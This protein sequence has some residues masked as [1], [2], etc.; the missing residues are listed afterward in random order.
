MAK[1]RAFKIFISSTF[2]DLV[3]E[4]NYIIDRVIKPFK[5]KAQLEYNVDVTVVDL[6]WGITPQEA[7]D[8]RVLEI[9]L[10]EIDNC[11]PLFIGI[12]GNR[13]GWC[14]PYEDFL[15][16]DFL[17]TRYP[18]MEEC[19]KQGLSITEMEMQY[20]AINSKIATDAIFFLQ[21]PDP[22]VQWTSGDKEGYEKLQRLRETISSNQS[23]T[24][25]KYKSGDLNSLS[26]GSLVHQLYEWLMRELTK[27]FPEKEESE[28]DLPICF[29]T[30]E[31]R[32][33]YLL[34]KLS[35]NAKTISDQ[36]AEIILGSEYAQTPWGM[37]SFI[38]DM[39][40]FGVFEEL[41]T[42]INWRA[43]VSIHEYD[44]F[45]WKRRFSMYSTYMIHT[46]QALA[47]SRNGVDTALAD[48][49]FYQDFIH[50]DEELYGSVFWDEMILS[51]LVDCVRNENGLLYTIADRY[52]DVACKLLLPDEDTIERTRIRLIEAILDG[53][54]YDKYFE[55]TSQEDSLY[56]EL[57]YQKAHCP[58]LERYACNW[59]DVCCS[60]MKNSFG[61]EYKTLNQIKEEGVNTLEDYRRVYAEARL[62]YEIYCTKNEGRLFDLLDYVRYHT[63]AEE[64]LPEN[65]IL[66]WKYLLD[67]KAPLSLL[68]AKSEFI[69]ESA[70]SWCDNIDYDID[71]L[72]PRIDDD[73]DLIGYEGDLDENL[74]PHGFGKAYYGNS[75]TYEGQWEHGKMHGYGIYE[76][77]GEYVYEGQFCD[78]RKEGK[79]AICYL[80]DCDG[81][82]M[83][84]RLEG[85][86]EYDQLNGYGTIRYASGHVYQGEFVDGKF[87][88]KGVYTSYWFRYEGDF[89]YGKFQG[90]G[91]LEFSEGKTFEGNFVDDCM[92]GEGVLC[93]PNGA[94]VAGCWEDD[95][96]VGL[97]TLT[98]PDGQQY[99]REY[100]DSEPEW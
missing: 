36:Q 75:D 18:E 86:F 72:F 23:I 30:I 26:Y 77:A 69:W 42:F 94:T 5:V 39:L 53:E 58:S 2:Q 80:S 85:E 73:M 71:S 99:Q 54:D 21:E 35:E 17:R 66:A 49:V 96:R 25:Y 81:Y 68:D 83:G 4:R 78:G 60:I 34:D 12:I 22:L 33:K 27:Y 28:D 50:K 48:K 46:L 45:V 16:N 100:T 1:K 74:L 32:K 55:Y 14:P 51:G 43:N 37:N 6:R 62:Y 40:T 13:Y 44:E 67:Y 64:I 56:Q 19:F 76:G 92:N 89:V 11:R 88:G 15:K 87:E 47:V 59:E 10:R 8:G 7:K 93:F 63:D 95:R 20:G 84:D 97:F 9:C 29:D 65:E 91:K 38:D 98:L 90:H 31:Q 24:T 70:S 82:E 61:L 3:R 79:G 57:M 52:R 41:D